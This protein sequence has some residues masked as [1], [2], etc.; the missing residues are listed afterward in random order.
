[1]WCSL[2]LHGENAEQLIYDRMH[3]H[4]HNAHLHTLVSVNESLTFECG[5]CPAEC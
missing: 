3:M 2:K 5:E 1:M 4:M